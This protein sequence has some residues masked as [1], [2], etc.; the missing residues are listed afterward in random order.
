MK[1][2]TPLESFERF[3]AGAG[4][5]DP[6]ALWEAAAGYKTVDLDA[7]RNARSSV[8]DWW[9]SLDYAEKSSLSILLPNWLKLARHL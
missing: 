7:W 2:V 6:L 4:L 8:L 1:G 5:Q 3:A 9:E